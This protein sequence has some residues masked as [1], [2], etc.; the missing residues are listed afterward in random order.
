MDEHLSW[1]YH[2]CQL[3][4][5]L[6]RTCGILLKIRKYLTIDMMKSIYNSLF[7]SLLQCG[8]TV[9]GQTYESYREPIFKLQKR[10]SGSH[11]IRHRVP[12][13]CLSL[14]KDLQLLRLSEIFN[15]KLLTFVYE[16]I[17]L[18]TPS[19]FHGYFSFNSAVHNYTF[20]PQCESLVFCV[21][22]FRNNCFKFKF[23]MY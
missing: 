1:N 16:S 22:M 13:P 2:L 11:Q 21:L 18:I 7:I 15:F 12:I 3:S 14:F 17:K 8:I 5:K 10:P 4:K 19:C 20:I 9:L 23:K 6:S